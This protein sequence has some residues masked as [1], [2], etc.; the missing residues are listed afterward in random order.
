MDTDNQLG[1]RQRELDRRNMKDMRERQGNF[2]W[3]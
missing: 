3:D 2:G 1:G